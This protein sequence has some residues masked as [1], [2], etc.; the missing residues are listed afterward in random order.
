MH[1]GKKLNINIQKK[2]SH[3]ESTNE[4]S[5]IYTIMSNKFSLCYYH[6]QYY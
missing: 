6:Q 5:D 2:S 3:K 1:I 4:Q